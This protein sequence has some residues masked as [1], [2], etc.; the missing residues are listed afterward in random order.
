MFALILVALAQAPATSPSTLNP[1][2]GGVVTNTDSY[3]ES[4]RTMNAIE[5]TAAAAERTAA[6]AEKIAQLQSGQKGADAAAPAELADAQGWT[7]TMGIGLVSLTGNSESLTLTGLVNLERKTEHWIVRAKANGAYGQARAAADA[8]TDADVVAMRA[9]GEL[10]GDRRFGERATGFV[11]VGADTDH[12]KSVEERFYGEAGASMVWLDDKT[13]EFQRLLLRTDLAL[14]YVNEIRFQY[15]PTP[16]NVDDVSLFGPRFGVAFRYGISKDTSFVQDAEVIP[17][18]TGGAG[19]VL[20][21]STSK[22]SSKLTS[23]FALS[24]GFTVT[25]DSLPAPGK[26]TTDTALIAGIDLTL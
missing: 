12:V 18:I 24:I 9:L 4:E 15:Y 11:M 25:H 10:R 19:R 23:S 3:L 5:R 16:L 14:R 20:F 1:T 17:D 21:N 6:A 8:T 2:D 26:R 7:G 22:I 13:E